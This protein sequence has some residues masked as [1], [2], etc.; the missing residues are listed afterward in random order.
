MNVTSK[1]LVTLVLALIPYGCS[2]KMTPAEY[3]RY[4]EKNRLKYSKV[5]ECSGVSVTVTLM[6]TEY[7][8]AREMEAD[9]CLNIDTLFSN[10]SKTLIIVLSASSAAAEFENGS[11]LVQSSNMA[12]FRKKLI[13]TTF[14]PVNNFFITD[15]FDTITAANCNYERSWGIGNED[16]FLLT[17]PACKLKRNLK[18]YNII[19]RELSPAIGT[20][21]VRIADLEK[22]KVKLEGCRYGI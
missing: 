13:N 2:T 11:P 5:I 15:G 16:T 21:E 12:D 4:F 3:L 7:H 6:P 14:L 17:F 20:I 1:A 22:R 9:S 19:I 18:E 10:Y 8:V